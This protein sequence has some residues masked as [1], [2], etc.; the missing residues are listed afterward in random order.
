MITKTRDIFIIQGA[1]E[2]AAEVSRIYQAYG[3]AEVFGMVE[4]DAADVSTKRKREAMFA[5]FQKHL[6]NPGNP[7]D[8]EVPLLSETE[9]KVTPTGQV[10]TSF[11]GESVF[12]LNRA[13][14]QRGKQSGPVVT[15]AKVVIDQAKKLSG[16]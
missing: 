14:I 10:S 1:R 11:G 5:F 12:S 13:E 2:T 4:V 9:M 6:D 16:Y 15:A 8:E 7:L 3:K